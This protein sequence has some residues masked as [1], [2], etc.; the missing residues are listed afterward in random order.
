MSN[1]SEIIK[2]SKPTTKSSGAAP[3]IGGSS[4]ARMPMLAAWARH[5]PALWVFFG[6]QNPRRQRRP[7]LS[8][9]SDRILR[10]IGLT[11][12]EVRRL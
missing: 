4:S 12:D 8:D 7:R 5:L 6:N 10:D 11:R 9:L 3:D 1:P 2:A